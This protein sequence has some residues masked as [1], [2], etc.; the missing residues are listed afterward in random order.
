E[1]VDGA[2]L[3][4]P[5]DLFAVAVLLMEAWSGTAPFRRASPADSDAAM[6]TPHPK[7]SDVDPRLAPLDEPI[8]RAMSL[9]PKQ[10]PQEAEEPG[11]ALRKFMAA[12]DSA[13][14]AR[15]L[16]AHVRAARKAISRKR[17][18]AVNKGPEWKPSQPSHADVGPK[19]FAAREEIGIWKKS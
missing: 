16:G 2:P 3:G 11:R 13:D 6:H 4:P 12:V 7:P 5:T 10:R 9:D 15:D 14:V 17:A 18:K 1:Q 8:Q 19:T